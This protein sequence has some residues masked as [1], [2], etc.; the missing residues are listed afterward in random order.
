VQP[1]ELA[2]LAVLL[3]A[4]DLLARRADQVRMAA[5]VLRPMLITTG[6]LCL[7]VMA[8]PDMGTTMLIVLVVLA[9]LFVGGVPLGRM[10]S[11][12]VV[13]LLGALALAKVEGYRWARILSFR[14]PFGDPTNT[15]YQVAQSLVALGTGGVGGVGLGASRAKWGYLPNAHTDF[16]FAI[17]GEELGLIGSVAVVAMFVAFAVLGVRAACRAPDR[18]GALVAAGV[19]AWVSGQAFVN[20]GAV[21]GLLPVTGVP[22][23]FVSFGGS[24]LIVT[25]ASVGILLNIA[26][27]PV[28]GPSRRVGA[29]AG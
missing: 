19:T 5:A 10:M 24:S 15:G 21:T 16:I 17:V 12:A 20:M 22:L 25:M 11:V 29:T 3:F 13:T 28:P 7:L 9:E 4:A 18:F 1:S 2:K 26:R 6:L 23:P 8:Q 14:N 27:Q